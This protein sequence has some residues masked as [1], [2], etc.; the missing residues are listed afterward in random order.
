VRRCLGEERGKA[1]EP[2]PRTDVVLLISL[3]SPLPVKLLLLQFG[4]NPLLLLSTTS[5]KNWLG[6]HSGFFSILSVDFI[7]IHSTGS[8]AEP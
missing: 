1:L 4:G 3:L 5:V 6:V 7:W 2:L 8:V